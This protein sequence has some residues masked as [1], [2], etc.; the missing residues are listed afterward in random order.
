[1]ILKLENT[2]THQEYEYNVVDTNNGEK[3]YF[4]FDIN[5]LE[6]VDGEY[7]LTLYDGD[8]VVCTDLLRIG[9]FNP[10]T[11]QYKSGDNTYIAIQLDAKI[12][13]KS[14]QISTITSTIYPDDGFDG[15]DSVNIDAQPVFDNGYNQGRQDGY[16]DGKEQGIEEQKS[17]LIDLTVT[18]NGTYEKEDGY[19]KV[20]V[21]VPDLNGSY[22][23]GYSQG[24]ENGKQSGYDEG[25]LVGKEN[26]YTE[27]VEIGKEIGINQSGEII[28]QNAEVLNVTRNGTYYTKYSDNIPPIEITGD[29]DFTEF[30]EIDGAIYN[31]NIYATP[32]T[33]VELWYNNEKFGK[34]SYDNYVIGTQPGQYNSTNNFKIFYQNYYEKFTAEINGRQIDFVFSYKG[35][36]HIVMSFADGFYLNGE[37]IGNFMK[38]IKENETS[39]LP[40]YINGDYN[41]RGATSNTYGMIK[42]NDDVIIPTPEG[43]LNTSTDEYLEVLKNGY[44]TYR[45]PKEEILK[46]FIKEVRVETKINVFEN[47]ICLAYSNFNVVPDSLDFSG[48]PV[49]LEHFFYNCLNLQELPY[50]DTSA[51]RNYNSWISNTN[52]FLGTIPFPIYINSDS[53]EYMFS[54]TSIKELPFFDTSSVKNFH[55]FCGN[56]RNITTIP[57]YDTSKATDVTYFLENCTGLISLP[58]FDF[59]SLNGDLNYLVGF[60]SDLTNLTEIGG[61]LNLKVNSN[62][63]YS[64]KK[65][66]NLSY[67]SCI[68]VL[69]GL[70]DFR[71][72]G[73]ETTTKTLKVHQN[74]LDAVGDEISIGTN[75]GWVITT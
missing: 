60:G 62:S 69:N 1:M 56:N 16:N 55:S 18:E 12:G 24:F 19:S 37:K 17:K 20:I 27:G 64:F 73:D 33:R 54:H 14:Q 36:H 45:N 65:L 59:G 25:Y 9:D 49:S 10:N 50:I 21:D 22:D 8:N 44:Y 74:F 35:W 51:V 53:V 7:N 63:N 4:Q 34:A 48:Q 42:I 46:N 40:L 58:A 75:K 39:S 13:G 5:T 43:F 3:L 72:N 66:P 61:F 15:M 57:P 11:L 67:Q 28:A 47:K 26:G 68:N 38:N 32:T 30:A 70:Y 31:T 52:G 29:N 71:G 23:D 6:L 41:L 2:T